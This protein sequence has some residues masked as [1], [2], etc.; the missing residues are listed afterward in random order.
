MVTVLWVTHI[1]FNASSFVG[2]IMIIGI[3]AE[4]GVFVMHEVKGA[5]ES[6]DDLDSALIHAGQRRARPIIM[7]TLAAI[8]PLLPLALGLGTGAQMQQP[9]AIAVI[10]GFCVSSLLLFFV[11]PLVYRSMSRR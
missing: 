4:N 8:L 10:G 9:L 7:T 6:G 5:R 11:L 1:T 3:V 2:L